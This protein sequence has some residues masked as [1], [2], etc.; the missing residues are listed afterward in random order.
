[1]FKKITKIA[2]LLGFPFIFVSKIFAD[3]PPKLTQQQIDAMVD[4]ITSKIVPFATLL[5]FVFVVYAGYMWMISA[6]DPDKVKKAQ[7]TLQWAVIG[8]VFVVIT[9]L[10]IKAILNAVN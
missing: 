7:G 3:E 5:A 2:L 1:M 9:S 10:I 4:S 6:G 8:L